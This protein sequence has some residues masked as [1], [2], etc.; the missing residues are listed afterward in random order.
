MLS[1]EKEENS[2]PMQRGVPA[3]DRIEWGKGLYVAHANR[4][5]ESEGRIKK[6]GGEEIKRKPT[7]HRR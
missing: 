5:E 3:T 2:E 6:R 7:T 1:G 4:S